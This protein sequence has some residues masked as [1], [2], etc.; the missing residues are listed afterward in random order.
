MGCERIHLCALSVKLRGNCD[1]C[2]IAS[3]PAE[4]LLNFGQVVCWPLRADD[5]QVLHLDL[6]C[7]N[8]Q[9]CKLRHHTFDTDQCAIKRCTTKNSLV[10]PTCLLPQLRRRLK[11]NYEMS[12]SSASPLSPSLAQ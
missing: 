12:F 6:L 11:H 3:I 8:S 4:T 5:E 1:F 10:H 9:E 2:S 7:T